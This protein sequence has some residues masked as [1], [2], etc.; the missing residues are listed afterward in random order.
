MHL[1]KIVRKR[2]VAVFLNGDRNFVGAIK[3]ASPA[4]VA[5]Y[6]KR[7]N[8]HDIQG[9]NSLTYIRWDDV[10]RNNADVLFLG[11]TSVFS[12]GHRDFRHIG[13]A[14][15]ILLPLSFFSVLCIYFVLRHVGRQKLAFCGSI[16]IPFKTGRMRWFVFKNVNKRHRTGPLFYFSVGKDEKSFFRKIRHLNYCVLPGGKKTEPIKDLKILVLNEH[17]DDLMRQVN[18]R[19]G[20]SPIEI[21]TAFS[22]PG[23]SLRNHVSYFPPARALDI[24]NRSTI[25]EFGRRRPTPKDALLAYCY[26]L[27]FHETAPE[28]GPRGEIHATTWK[29]KSCYVELM[30]LCD[31]ANISW[32][33]TIEKVENLLLR[34]GWF[35]SSETLAF[36]ARDNQFVRERYLDFLGYK[37][38]L[39][40][41]VIR[42]LAERHGL[43]DEIQKMIVSAG[44]EILKSAPIPTDKRQAVTAQFRGGNWTLPAG[45][46][47]PVYFI[48]AF[49]R[50]PMAV[51]PKLFR[52]A[53]TTDNGRLAIKRDIRKKA[54]SIAGIKSFNAL[55]SSDNSRAAL[56]YVDILSP[57]LYETC[58]AL[59]TQTDIQTAYPKR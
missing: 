40:V 22:V 14:T 46:G 58:K 1:Q 2:K 26:H 8:V 5:L 4:A 12:I 16:L 13:H 47:P 19:F 23:H 39:A 45:A 56:E 37:P 24:L 53:S 57:D 10:G 25:D 50:S 29:A 52:D 41:F 33:P 9:V 17:V 30:R 7:P 27:L 48:I 49:D 20:S 32:I 31:E 3:A 11:G 35:P 42:E 38:G 18:S 28:F 43:V 34:E 6:R 59:V 55:H 36:I 54:A 51:D 21:Y 44:Y 15:Y